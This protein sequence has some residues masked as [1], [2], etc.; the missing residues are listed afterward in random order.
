MAEPTGEFLPGTIQMFV[1]GESGDLRDQELTLTPPPTDS[2]NDPLNWSLWRK[3]W[4]ST[5]VLFVTALTAATANDAGAGGDGMLYE[6]G[7]PYSVANTAAGVLF[8]AIGFWTLLASPMPWLYGR[9]IQYLVCLLWGVVG[10]IWFARIQNRQDSI[11]NQMFVGAS[12]SCAEALVQLSLSDLF[13][14]H[15]RGTVLG[16]YILA[17][18]IG[19]FLGPLVAGYIAIDSWRWIGWT[20]ALICGGTMI[21]FYFGLEETSFHREAILGQ[22][23]GNPSASQTL[24][25]DEKT[26]GSQDQNDTDARESTDSEAMRFTD[27]K[28]TYWQRIALITPAPNMLGTGLKQ[29]FYRLYHTLRVFLFPA[30]LYSGLQWGAQDAWLSFYL[31]VE[32][33]NYYDPPW[34]YSNQAVAIMNIPTLI[35]ATMGCIYGG[36]FSDIFVGWMAKRRGGISEAED[37][38]WLM[39]LSAIINPAGLILFGVGSGKGWSWPAPY[40]GLAM[41][42]FGFGCAG[43]LSMAYLMD[44]YPDMVLEGMVG[45]AV[46]NN[47]LACIFTFTCSYWIDASGLSNTF[48][49][50]GVLSFFFHLLTIPM[51]VWGK[52]C[53][54]WTYKGY[55]RFLYLRDGEQ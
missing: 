48:I 29:Y 32:E 28:K 11:W 9:R 44:A 41:T 21:V 54:R 23:A 50:I 7:I 16:I 36:Y 20:G 26:T 3:Y 14:Q 4:H 40:V 5:L 19:T 34:N 24:D 42:G 27:K 12:E 33:D 46:I 6:L 51:M 37:R 2:P 30:V 38:L 35:G 39:F 22:H 25:N 53:R 55:Q 47:T 17:T 52:A 1:Q 10:S 49:A 18:S 8:L 43:D 13:F 45:V 31:T 15:Q